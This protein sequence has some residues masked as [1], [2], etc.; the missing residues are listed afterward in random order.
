[1]KFSEVITSDK[2][3]VHEKGQGQ[4]WKVKVTEVKANFAPIGAFPD[5]N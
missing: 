1:M 2:R 5:H 4:K 3:D